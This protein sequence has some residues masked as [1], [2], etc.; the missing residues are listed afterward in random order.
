MLVV[1]IVDMLPQIPEDFILISTWLIPGVAPQLPADRRSNFLVNKLPASFHKSLINNTINF[2]PCRT[3][4]RALRFSVSL[5]YYAGSARYLPDRH[6]DDDAAHHLLEKGVNPESTRPLPI[7]VITSTPSSVPNK[8]R[9]R[10]KAPY[11]R[12]RPRR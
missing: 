4:A 9:D 6:H 2:H 12:P 11:R 5:Y 10:R 3:R 7:S 8:S 1:D